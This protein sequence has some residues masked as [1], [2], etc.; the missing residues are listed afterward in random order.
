MVLDF[1]ILNLKLSIF[2]KQNIYYVISCFFKYVF[3]ICTLTH[4]IV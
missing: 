1:N 4:L 3:F 2:F